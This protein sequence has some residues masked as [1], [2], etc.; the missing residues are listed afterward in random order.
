M[1]YVLAENPYGMY[2]PKRRKRRR[3][4]AIGSAKN[5][6]RGI[7]P[8]EFLAGFANM[9]LTSWAPGYLIKSIASTSDKLLRVGAA[10]LTAGVGAAVMGAVVKDARVAKAAALTGFTSAAIQALAVFNVAQVGKGGRSLAGVNRAGRVAAPGGRG[11][12][13]NPAIPTN[14][15]LS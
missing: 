10:V 5:W 11:I 6:A 12:G 13:A 1:D 14:A 15:R 3:N 8:Q 4:P 7:T 2:K 9:V